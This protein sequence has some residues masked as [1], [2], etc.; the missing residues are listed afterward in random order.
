MDDF[1]AS[2]E[3]DFAVNHRRRRVKRELALRVQVA[4]DAAA[5]FEVDAQDFVGKV[6]EEGLHS[7]GR[8]QDRDRSARVAD[9][10]EARDF[11][12]VA[13]ADAVKDFVTAAK[14]GDA[15][16]DAGRAVDVILGLELPERL[17]GA[18]F[19][20]IERTVVRPDQHAVSDNDR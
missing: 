14:I 16:Y 18:R 11:F 13:D 8:V 9:A 6:A 12:A 19:K 2:A 17:A 20:T 5:R 10:R 7:G 1:V 4:P 3:D 15:V